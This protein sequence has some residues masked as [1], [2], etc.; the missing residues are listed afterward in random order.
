MESDHNQDDLLT[1]LLGRH[2]AAFA[3]ETETAQVDLR[4]PEPFVFSRQR[5]LAAK[6]AATRM[7]ALPA[8]PVRGGGN[9]FCRCVWI[10]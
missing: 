7:P 9:R 3:C 1:H 4:L 5:P 6:R 10:A 8:E 2:K